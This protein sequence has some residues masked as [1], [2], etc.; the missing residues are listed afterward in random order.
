[1]R[2]CKA[3]G[4]RSVRV[5]AAIGL[6]VY[7]LA[8]SG[9]PLTLEQAVRIAEDANPALRSARAAMHAAEGELSE[10]RAPLWNN[11]EVSLEGS[12]TRV[13]RAVPGERYNAW[14]A[15]VSQAFET[16]GQQGRR[17]LAAQAEI[18]AVSASIEEGLASLRAE[19]EQRF[20]QVLA[21][22]ARAAVEQQTLA[23]V[24]QA[25]AAMMKRL[26]AGEVG[27]LDANLARVEAERARNQL[28][29]LDEQLTHARAELAALLQLPPGELPEA[30]GELRRD[31]DYTLDQLMAAAP[32]RRLLESLA[33]REEAARRRLDLQRAGRY[34]D[35]TVGLFAGRDGPGDLR[36]NI[37]GL[38]VSVPLPLFRRNEGGIG[39]ALT[40]L[41]QIQVERQA[42][43][44]DALAGVRAQ[45]QR[46][47]QLEARAARLR[48]RVLKTL[49][50]NQR[51]SQMAL[52]EGEIGVA[53]LL[54]VNRQ[55]AE[56]R[57]ELL[58]A[59][60]ELRLA[61]IAL[62]RAAGWPPMDSKETK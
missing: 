58:D 8:A 50:D 18:A 62:E 59:E 54:L 5:S 35:V 44:R 34:P 31:A 38:S 28:V 13:P 30:V 36:E 27:R 48:G 43:E 39:R 49:E 42:A 52:R 25:A 32:R 47:A 45:W 56:T 57:R 37:V 20:I 1:M 60:T 33:Q 2:H 11:P 46:V 4:A 10:S 55:V 12:R 53:E 3:A 7:M 22:Q 14:S 29:Q 15:G 41:A 24:E 61:R 19:V 17:R 16:A 40:E 26:E 51:L 21:L 9:A 23:I 6:A